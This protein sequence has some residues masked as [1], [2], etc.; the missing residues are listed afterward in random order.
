MSRKD[1]GCR[2]KITGFQET[3]LTTPILTEKEV[4]ARVEVYRDM[5][6]VSE[7]PGFEPFQTHNFIGMTTYTASS[8]SGLPAQR[9]C[10]RRAGST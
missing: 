6:K 8:S 2:K 1:P 4:Q 9:Y 10:W 7:M 5:G 3:R